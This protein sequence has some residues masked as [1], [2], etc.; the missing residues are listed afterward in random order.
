M[1]SVEA[2]EQLIRRLRKIEGQTQGI[3]RM[4]AEERECREVLN[5]LASVKAATHR[6][7]LELAKHHILACLNDPECATTEESVN[8]L[9]KHL[10][11]I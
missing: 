11:R 1:L 3:Q 2:R 6:V 8:D 10:V 4:L 9:I 5:Q 7:S